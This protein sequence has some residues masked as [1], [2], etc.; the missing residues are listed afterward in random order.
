M[1]YS[2]DRAIDAASSCVALRG[3]YSFVGD[4]MVLKVSYS[5]HAVAFV[6]SLELWLGTSDDWIGASDRPTKEQGPEASELYHIIYTIICVIYV[7]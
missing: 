1:L 6:S 4:G 2:C 5:F 7:T 3:S